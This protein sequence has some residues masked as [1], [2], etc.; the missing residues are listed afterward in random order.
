MKTIN[1]QEPQLEKDEKGRLR[2]VYVQFGPHYFVDIMP[3]EEGE[4]TLY[5]GATHHGF[6]A[7]A[8]GVGDQLEKIIEEIRQLHPELI[9]D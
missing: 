9:F 3:N 5:L 2:R 1:I 7:R 8:S 6:S 4:L